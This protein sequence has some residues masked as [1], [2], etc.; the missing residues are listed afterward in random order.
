MWRS[1]KSPREAYTLQ[2]MWFDM[3]KRQLS[4]IIKKLLLY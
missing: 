4:Y 1:L 3:K 2:R